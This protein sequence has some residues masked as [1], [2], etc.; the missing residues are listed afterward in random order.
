MNRRRRAV[1]IPLLLLPLGGCSALGGL[2]GGLA[3]GIGS[4]FQL[5]LYLAAIAGPIYLSYWLYQRDKD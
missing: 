2:T 4:L 3:S 5:A 1:L